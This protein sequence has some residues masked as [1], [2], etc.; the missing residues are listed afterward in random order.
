[1]KH[2]IIKLSL[3]VLMSMTSNNTYSFSAKNDQG[4]TIYYNYIND[5]KELEVVRNGV[6][7]YTDYSNIII[8]EEVTY[9]GR[10]RKVTSIAEY[11]FKNCKKLSSI[12]IPRGIKAIGKSAFADC[13]GLRKVII[14]DIAAWCDIDFQDDSFSSSANPVYYAHHLYSDENTEIKELVIPNGVTI[15]KNYA[16]YN[17][18]G[19]TSVKIPNSVTEIG[20]STFAACI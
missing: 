17:C 18:Y 6:Y 11:T 8:P 16:F 13:F 10:T 3:I 7:T 20:V 14:K 9:M 15:I 2:L 1:M 12:S 4:I 19:I 5:N